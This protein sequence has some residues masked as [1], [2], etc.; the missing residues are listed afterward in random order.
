MCRYI[1]V[2]FTIARWSGPGLKRGSSYA[3]VCVVILQLTDVVLLMLAL[4]SVDKS[5]LQI[6]R[7]MSAVSFWG[8][9]VLVLKDTW[10]IHHNTSA[11]DCMF[12]DFA[13]STPCLLAP[14]RARNQNPFYTLW[15]KWNLEE[16][17]KN[18]VKQMKSAGYER[19]GGDWKACISRVNKGKKGARGWQM[20]L[21]SSQTLTRWW[22]SA[23]GSWQ[24]LN[25]S[26]LSFRWRGCETTARKAGN[27]WCKINEWQLGH[28]RCR[29]KYEK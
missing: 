29:R 23:Q 9:G 7:K 25:L 14:K 21:V 4:E 11:F 28:N 19:D 10:S 20:Y 1:F 6:K 16:E 5:C 13:T 12:L 8:K 2:C 24:V 15:W 18:S 3:Y 27:S 26:L 17:Y 22:W